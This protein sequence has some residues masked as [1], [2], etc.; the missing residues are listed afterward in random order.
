MQYEITTSRDRVLPTF[1]EALRKGSPVDMAVAE[2]KAISLE[3]ANTVEWG[4]RPYM[5]SPDG[6]LF[7]LMPLLQHPQ[8][9]KKCDRRPPYCWR[10]GA[11]R[12]K[13]GSRPPTSEAPTSDIF[14][15]YAHED[16][17]RVLPLITALKL[18]GAS[19]GPDDPAWM[20]ARHSSPG[21]P[22]LP[23]VLVVCLSVGQIDICAG[24]GGRG[25]ARNILLPLLLDAVTY[26]WV[27][28][29][30]T[31]DLT[32]WTAPGGAGVP[33][34]VRAICRFRGCEARDADRERESKAQL[35]ERVPES[36]TGTTWRNGASARRRVSGWAGSTLKLLRRR[37]RHQ[38][39]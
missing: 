21:D 33:A 19:S 7:N 30:Q 18:D 26:P 39:R 37:P 2:R 27:P 23:A 13:N 22:E 28:Q 11:A 34:P 31:A 20:T 24:G 14:L 29:R 32:H 5:R 8:R 15:S 16:Q 1:Y 4:R 12:R 3:V 25:N 17:N 36:I 9:R 38:V 10:Q 35:R 6:I